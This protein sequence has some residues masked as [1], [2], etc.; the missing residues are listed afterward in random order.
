MI[1]GEDRP[2]VPV[3]FV[4]IGFPVG[5]HNFPGMLAAELA[6]LI[7]NGVITLVDALILETDRG[8]EVHVHEME[9]L[10]AVRE[11]EHVRMVATDVIPRDDIGY[12][13][14]TME[15]GM[16]AGVLAWENTWAIPLGVGLQR[17]GCRIV[18]GSRIS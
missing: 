9:D 17:A 18:S 11:L 1:F 3:D 4:V 13:V 2:P 15:S 5:V 7:E 6:S 10:D 14:A 8:G 16:S 12:L